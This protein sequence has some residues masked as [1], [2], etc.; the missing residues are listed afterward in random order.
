MSQ[1]QKKFIADNSVDGAKIRLL[2]NQTFRARNNADDGDVDLFKLTTADVFEFLKQPRAGTGVPL[3]SASK[4]YVT[5]EYI[6]DIVLGKLDAKDAVNAVAVVDV[7]LTDTGALIVDGVNFGTATATPPK[8]IALTGQTAPEENG[9]YDYTYAAG[10]YTLVRSG[11]FNTSA[12]VTYGSYFKVV[13]GTVY[14]GYDCILTT[15]DP[16]VLG[17]TGL[18]FALNP[19]AISITAGDMLVKNVNELKVDLFS[20]GGLESSNPGNVSGQLRVKVDQEVAEKDKS[21]KLSATGE[22][23]AKKAKREQF[24]LAGSATYV[25]LA[26]VASQ[27]SIVFQVAGAGAQVEGTDYTVNYTGG[28]GSKTRITFAGGLASGG[29]SELVNGD[30]VQVFYSAFY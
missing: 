19:S 14:S 24:T 2:N 6:N 5:V 7:P 3:P 25:D 15:D 27:D 30:I 17:T 21:T 4:D 11:D 1:I 29:V 16:I 10:D 23:V 28:A 9:V 18:T 8:R 22:V 26:Y 13:A 12:E 20:N